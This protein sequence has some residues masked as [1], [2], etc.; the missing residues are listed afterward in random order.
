M[1]LREAI[2]T[3]FRKYFTFSGRARRP[4]YWY[5]LLLTI[6]VSMVPV[7][8]PLFAVAVLIPG[9]AV[10]WRR[11]HDIGKGG[12]CSLLPWAGAAFGA[13][14]IGLADGASPAAEQ[15]ARYLAVL[16][17]VGTS[18]ITLVWL[19]SPTKPGPNRFGPEPGTET[20]RVEGVFD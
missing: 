11:M 14:L 17:V 15:G 19:A 2:V 4:E 7:I 5:F 1:G 20:L 13:F 8:G 6:L 12:Y 9:Y 3:C 10:T 16:A 18:I